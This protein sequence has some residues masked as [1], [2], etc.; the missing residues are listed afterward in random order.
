MAF[1]S[2]LY[3]SASSRDSSLLSASGVRLVNE[4]TKLS[5]VQAKLS[6]V[7][8]TVEEYRSENALK[9]SELNNFKEH[10]AELLAGVNAVIPDTVAHVSASTNL[11][12][13]SS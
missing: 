4:E 2:S 5:L 12:Q 13:V 7:L 8:T 10:F 11:G 6:S 3:A 1:P 9:T